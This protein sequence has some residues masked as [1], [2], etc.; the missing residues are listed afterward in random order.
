MTDEPTDQP[1]DEPTDDARSADACPRCAAHR[2]AILE[3]PALT[4]TI[5]EPASDAFGI[6]S[7]TRQ[8]GVPGIGCLACGAEWPSLAAFRAEQLEGPGAAPVA[9]AG[10]HD[11]RT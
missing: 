3:F 1:T 5:H 7:E 4:S 8:P 2:L 11:A 10:A 9:E 6:V